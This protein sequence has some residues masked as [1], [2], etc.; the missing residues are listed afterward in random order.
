MLTVA[1]AFAVPLVVLLASVRTSVG[2]WDTG[3]LQTVAWIA[4]IPYPTGFPGYV[5]LG[6]LWTHALPVASVAWRLNALSAVAVAAGAATVTAIA[7]LY[8]VLPPIAVA[9]GWM[10]AFAHAMWARASYADAHPVGF[11]VAFIAIALAIRWTRRGEPRSLAL[12]LVMAGVALAIDNT[13]VLMLAAVPLVAFARRPPW[14]V[15]ALAAVGAIA[16]VLAAYAYLPLRSAQVTAAR[17]DPTLALGIEPGRP[18][19]DDHDPRT[20]D[21]FTA[22]VTGA[23]WL[24][25]RTLAKIF[26]SDAIARS[27]DRF[28]P[29]LL[30]DYPQGLL[31]VA[32]FGLAFVALADPLV[33]LMLVLAATL[34]ALFGGSYPVEADPNRYIFMLYAVIAVGIAIAADRTARAFGGSAPAAA[35]GVVLSV[36][37]A[38]LIVDVV[39]ANDI[40]AVRGNTDAADFGA[41]VVSATHDRAVIVAAWDLATPL[42]YRAYVE[43]AMGNRILVCALPT[44]HLVEYA[45]W[46]RDRQVAIVLEKRPDLPGFTS[47]LLSGGSPQ[48]YEIRRL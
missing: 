9:G 41:R 25:D 32:G 35:R 43:H 40:F 24:P 8:D 27:A 47:R 19:W 13:T 39:S 46:M 29:E 1:V 23:E 34:P 22:L 2:F 14:R 48:I 44:D 12:A 26:T 33:A 38:V 28:E 16:I 21:G 30:S 5:M 36:L 45:G 17:L 31:V 18:F 11:A 3:D 4:G 42:A 20:M 15:T 6:W 37:A 7:L 10:F